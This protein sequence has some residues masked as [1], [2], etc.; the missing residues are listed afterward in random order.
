MLYYKMN[1]TVRLDVLNPE[2]GDTLK[3]YLEKYSKY[4]VFE[5]VSSKTQKLHYQGVV[6]FDS[7]Q[8]YKA[9]KVRFSSMFKSHTRGKKSMAKVKSEDYEIYISKDGKCFIAKEYTEED[10]AILHSKSYKKTDKKKDKKSWFMILVDHVKS[11]G[12]N[13]NSSGWE[14][15]AVV[16]DC[17]QNFCKCEPSDFQIQNYAKSIQRHLCFEECKANGNMNPYKSYLRARAKQVIGNTW[18]VVPF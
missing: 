11:E 2:D 15:A 8:E 12:L 13:S 4:L 14:I 3:K 16:I 17:Y 18:V 5:E 6:Y 1:Y 7:E 9:A 10:I